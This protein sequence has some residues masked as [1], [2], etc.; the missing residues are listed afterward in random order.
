MYSLDYHFVCIALKMAN[1]VG[2]N[3]EYLDAVVQ[4][5]VHVMT[6]AVFLGVFPQFMRP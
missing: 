3:E 1:K 5:A 6:S 2:R 4:H